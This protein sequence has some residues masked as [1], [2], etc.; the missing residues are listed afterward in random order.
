MR[1]WSICWGGSI[2]LRPPYIKGVLWN[3]SHA[4]FMKKFLYNNSILIDRRKDLRTHQTE[5]E[6]RLWSCLSGK[7][8]NGLRF[9]RQY[10]VGPY[11]LDFYCSKLRLAI[12]LDGNRHNEEEAKLY[13]K[14]RD[15]YLKSVSIET[16]RFW[17]S[18][19]EKDIDGVVSKIK[20]FAKQTINPS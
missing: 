9:Y 1:R 13:D 10:S 20:K 18:E 6:D 7:Q 15:N 19:V 8:I 5:A 14:D 16:L 2:H 12:E 11:I 4:I 17:N 3:A